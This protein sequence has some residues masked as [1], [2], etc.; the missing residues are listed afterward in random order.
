MMRI[1]VSLLLLIVAGCGGPAESPTTITLA[2]TTSTRDSG[3]LDVLV[4]AF[5]RQTGVEVKV[6]AVGSGQALEMGR[7]GDADVLLSHAPDA[8]QKFVAEGYG[9]R[10]RLVMHND[11]VLVGPESDSA[12]VKDED[13]IVAVLAQIADSEAAF[14]SR[15]DESGTHMKEQS[16]WEQA[17]IA[18][19]GSWYIEAGSGMAQ[20]LRMASE[21]GAYTLSDRGTFLSQRKGLDL[22]I[23]FSGDPLLRN[24]YAV[25]PVDPEKHPH[26]E[27]EAARRFADFLLAPKAQRTIGDFGVKK[28]GQPLFFPNEPAGTVDSP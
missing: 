14:V 15:G 24:Q 22:A 8:E 3:L 13:S 2:T 23:V 17:G 10:R 5:E 16:I 20:T 12:G 27:A 28:Y 25:I 7:R 26:V 19:Q 6:I 9:A 4:P 18:P 1:L 11:F 21:K